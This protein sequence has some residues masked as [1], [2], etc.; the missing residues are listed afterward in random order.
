MSTDSEISEK[1]TIKPQQRLSVMR[2]LEITAYGIHHRLWRS[3]LTLGVVTV[4]V[5]FL[6]N[7]LTESTIATSGRCPHWPGAWA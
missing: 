3:S 7:I 6:M 5:A 2:Q 1:L 4:A